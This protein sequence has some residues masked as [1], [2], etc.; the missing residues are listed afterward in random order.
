M[1]RP[2]EPL[3]RLARRGARSG[4]LAVTVPTA[5]RVLPATHVPSLAPRPAAAG[6]EPRLTVGQV[7]HR[8]ENAL[9]TAELAGELATVVGRVQTRLSVLEEAV[10]EAADGELRA[11]L[12]HRQLRRAV[13]AAEHFAESL[14][15]A[16]FVLTFA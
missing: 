14:T 15:E 16:E 2:P 12:A 7:D 1:V 13:S 10:G 3:V 11:A 9:G 4:G 5:R 6:D 8:Y